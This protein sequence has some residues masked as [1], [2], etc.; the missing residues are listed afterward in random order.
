MITKPKKGINSTLIEKVNND[1]KKSEHSSRT[2]LVPHT[3]QNTNEL[4][5]SVLRTSLASEPLRFSSRFP[6]TLRIARTASWY[7]LWPII[8]LHMAFVMKLTPLRTGGLFISSS[9]GGSV[10]SASAPTASIKLTQSNCTAVSGVD[11]ESYVE[12]SHYSVIAQNKI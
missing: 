10:A 3:W 11:P 4:N 12:N 5:I 7:A 6:S 1:S 8:F 9:F 2:G